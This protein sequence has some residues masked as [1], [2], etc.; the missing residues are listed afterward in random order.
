MEFYKFDNMEMSAIVVKVPGET[1]LALRFHK[2]PI[3]F[4]A[5][6]VGGQA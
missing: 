1:G 6:N 2:S 4:A 3:L 5:G